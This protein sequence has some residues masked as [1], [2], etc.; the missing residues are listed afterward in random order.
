MKH[1]AWGAAERPVSRL[2]SLVRYVDPA[3]EGKGRV[4]GRLNA[5]LRRLGTRGLCRTARGRPTRWPCGTLLPPDSIV[6]AT[7]TI[8][9][10][11]RDP[12]QHARPLPRRIERRLDS[13]G[14]L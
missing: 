14:T 1:G 10:P 4:S 5:F 12:H 7:E 2:F 8:A 9:M 11:V 3:R 6:Q 13:W